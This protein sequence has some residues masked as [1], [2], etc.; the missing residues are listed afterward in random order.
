[1]FPGVSFP[2]PYKKA[3]LNNST[4]VTPP[5]HQTNLPALKKILAKNAITFCIRI[6]GSA[7][8]VRI[9]FL[10]K[11]HLQEQRATYHMFDVI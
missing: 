11:H 1:M 4:V 5:P 2:Q 9:E 7:A 10:L 8:S 3:N 6:F